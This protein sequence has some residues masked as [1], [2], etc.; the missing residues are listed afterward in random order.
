MAIKNMNKQQMPHFNIIVNYIQ[1]KM[2]AASRYSFD[3]GEVHI[4][5][6]DTVKFCNWYFIYDVAT[7]KLEHYKGE[8]FSTFKAVIPKKYISYFYSEI[9]KIIQQMHGVYV[10]YLPYEIKHYKNFKLHR[11]DGP[12][13]IRYQHDKNN[14]ERIP[15]IEWYCIDNKTHRENG[16]AIIHYNHIGV[17][18]EEY[19][20]NG[21]LHRVGGPALINYDPETKKIINKSFFHHGEEQNFIQNETAV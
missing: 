18:K 1:D 2:I 10:L 20:I 3:A 4:A 14:L 6:N 7:K 15:A 9:D 8:S 13:Y 17:H 16:P 11:E 5:F 19:V 21:K 12:A